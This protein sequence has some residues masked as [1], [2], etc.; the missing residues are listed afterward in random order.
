MS[1][2]SKLIYDTTLLPVTADSAVVDSSDSNV[3]MVVSIVEPPKPKLPTEV[4]VRKAVFDTAR[5]YS[6]FVRERKGSNNHAAIRKFN[7][8]LELPLNSPYCSSFGVY[9]WR[10][11]G[12]RIPATDGTAYSWRK[13]SRL[14]WH[15]GLLHID[16]KLWPRIQI[17]DAVVYTWSHVGF[18]APDNVDGLTAQ[19]S[20]HGITVIGAN[21][22]GGVK[23]VE[24]VY[25]PIRRSMNYIYGIYDHFSPVY[26]ADPDGISERFLKLSI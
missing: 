23:R 1:C 12:I 15:R 7:R 24:G 10:A 14:V 21:T 16:D 19:Y 4:E 5:Y 25:Y 18:V 11:N 2:R 13:K 20:K 22:T 6:T 9:C 17:F 8:V 3:P 26:A